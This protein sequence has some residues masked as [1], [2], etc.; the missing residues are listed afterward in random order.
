MSRSW[1]LSCDVMIDVVLLQTVYKVLRRMHIGVVL[2]FQREGL[3]VEMVNTGHLVGHG[4]RPQSRIFSL[5][6]SSYSSS[7]LRWYSRLVRHSLR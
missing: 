6:A 1:L 5:S 2:E 7:H 3:L 4:R